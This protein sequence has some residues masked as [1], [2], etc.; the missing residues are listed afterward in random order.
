MSRVAKTY[1][2]G[3]CELGGHCSVMTAAT[4]HR[5]LL[6]RGDKKLRCMMFLRRESE[7]SQWEESRWLAW[8]L[9]EVA[10]HANAL[11]VSLDSHFNLAASP[12]H[13]NRPPRS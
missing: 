2:F 11:R 3:R 9:C 10:E 5:E 8:V 6:Q 1:L 13:I 7:R 12:L 4:K